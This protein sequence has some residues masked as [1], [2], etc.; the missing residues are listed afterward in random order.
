MFTP[1]GA[2]SF[3]REPVERL[4]NGTLAMEHEARR[5][6]LDLIE[7]QLFEAE[8][9]EARVGVVDQFLRERL[10]ERAADPVVTDAVER[11]RR[12]GGSL[13]IDALARDA[14]V[15]QS[16][17]ERRFRRVVGTSPKKFAGLVRL[18]KVVRL[19]RAGANFTEIA[20]ATGYADQPHFIKDFK[21]FTGCSPEN[22]F[23]VTAAFC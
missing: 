5:S 6:Q 12:S 11:I 21:R 10:R 19:R 7:E 1:T 23:R 4:F 15:S 17:L 9:D 2:A 22:F 14:R 16:A 13:R 20:H 3:L 18:R 8:H